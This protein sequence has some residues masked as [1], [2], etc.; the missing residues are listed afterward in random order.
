MTPIA[1]P[2]VAAIGA[3]LRDRRSFT[4]REI[5]A[6]KTLSSAVGRALAD[7]L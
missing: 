2:P 4:D 1:T 5:L 6:I 7:Y 3:Y